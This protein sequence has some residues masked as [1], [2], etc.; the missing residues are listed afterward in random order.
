[1]Q[2]VKLLITDGLSTD[3]LQMLE[4]SGQF[5]INFH[6]SVEKEALKGMLPSADAIIIRSA[7]KMT[8]DLIDL[9]PNLKVIMRA[10]AGVD[11]VDVDHATKKKV[12][13]LNCPGT[14]NNAVA[15]LTL[16][17]L[18]GL[19]REIPRATGGMKA[20]LWEKKDLVGNEAAGRTIGLLGF[21]AIGNLV[22][23]ACN[24]LGMKV[25]VFD[26]RS[27]ELSQKSEF[28][29]VKTWAANVD[30]VFA[31]SD[32]VSLHLPLMDS[33]KNSIGAT[34]FS[35]MKKGSYFINC[36]RGGIAN[37]AALLEA[38]N[39]GTL[40]GAALDVFDQEPTPADHPLVKHPKV[41][42]APHIGAATK[43]AQHKVGIAAAQYLIEYYK[44]GSAPSAVNHV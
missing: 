28:S 1:M 17:F 3:G 12:L 15:E 9:A 11:N 21:G 14:N 26:P 29:F 18:L 23:K 8:K 42:C 16:G 10:G 19:M 32:V 24:A 7:T 33:T 4:K 40:A 35:K 31:S 37:E 13:V 36:S 25:V 6:K 5:E 27:K 30:E 2:R 22:G 20:N 44:N 41:I 43:E 34:Q 38:L 39:S